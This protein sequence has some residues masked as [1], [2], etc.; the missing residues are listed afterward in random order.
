MII[1][2]LFI[3]MLI[4]RG[5][6]SRIC[7]KLTMECVNTP[8]HSINNICYRA[9]PDECCIRVIILVSLCLVR[10]GIIV[11]TVTSHLIWNHTYTLTHLGI[12]YSSQAVRNTLAMQTSCWFLPNHSNQG[13]GLNKG[14]QPE[15][16][17]RGLKD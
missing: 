4:I 3:Y 12:M 15:T 5:V 8:H 16:V 2:A 9:S 13:L 14:V 6:V 1:G 7:P 17:T 10:G 11:K